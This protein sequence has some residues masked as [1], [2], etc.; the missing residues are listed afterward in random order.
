[1]SHLTID[2]EAFERC[3]LGWVRT[4]FRADERAPRQITNAQI[5]SPRATRGSSG[6]TSDPTSRV[7]NVL[8]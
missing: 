4:V 1:M 7:A 5:A 2:P 6:N 3:F 8:A